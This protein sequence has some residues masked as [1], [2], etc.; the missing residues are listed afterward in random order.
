[1]G[2]RRALDVLYGRV[3]AATFD[4]VPRTGPV[5]YRVDSVEIQSKYYNGLRNTLEGVSKHAESY[6]DFASTHGRYHIPTDQ[7]RQLD[8]LRRTGEI[9][10]LSGRRADGI[11]GSLDDL[12]QA[13]GRSADDLIEPGEATYAEVQQ[14][15]VHDTIRKREDVLDRENK[16]LKRG[17]GGRARPIPG[18]P[19]SGR[20]SWRDCRGR[21]R[22]GAG[23]LGQAPR[24]QESLSGRV[25][26]AGLAGRRSG[27]GA[28][29][30][31]WRGCGWRSVRRD[32]L[33]CPGG[34]VRRL[35]R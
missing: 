1:M 5:D 3:P 2:V 9:E 22:S 6:P 12:E 35:A 21:H 28:G 27:G 11:R 14:G 23:D 18:G 19:R 29:R 17:G 4:G 8:E 26:D 34:T 7:H 33:H 16:E 15:R 32:E 31:W 13:T 30:Q 10:G 25:L 20:R 24:G